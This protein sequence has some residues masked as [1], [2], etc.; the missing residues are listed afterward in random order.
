MNTPMDA[1]VDTG[2]STAELQTPEAAEFTGKRVLV[3]GG[4][5]G[6]GEAIVNRLTRGGATVIA[7]ARSIPADHHAEQFIQADVSTRA[8]ADQ[9]IQTTFDRLGGI[10]ILINS[11]GGSSAPSGGVLALTDDIWQQ[12]FE[13]NLFSAV[14]LDR[15]F[16]PSML[17]QGSGV[18]IHISSIQR[19]LPLFEATLAY[20]AAKAA[21][22]NYSKGLSKEVGPRGIRVNTVAPGFT[23]TKAAEGLINRLATQAGTDSATA[24]QGLMNSLGGI[25]LG[26]PNR[27][28]EVAEL[29]A[30]LASDRAAS[31]IGSE[32]VIDGGTIPT[33]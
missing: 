27:P 4:T 7:T 10:D 25:S 28:E 23:E 29:V 20:A 13:L 3:T 19:T 6:I 22:T 32:F 33:V 11:V 2:R 30:F 24:R 31:I 16:L 18:I 9:V 5:K 8:G 1:A 21:L 15:G 17:K 12:E 26:R 14:R